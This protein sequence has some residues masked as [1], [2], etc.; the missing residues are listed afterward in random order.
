MPRLKKCSE[1]SGATGL[2]E[3]PERDVRLAEGVACA[4]CVSSDFRQEHGCTVREEW[5][6]V[7]TQSVIRFLSDGIRVNDIGTPEPVSS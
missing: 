1:S 4:L 7:L 2:L 5:T 6:Y 3:A